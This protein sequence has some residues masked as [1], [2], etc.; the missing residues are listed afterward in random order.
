[1]IYSNNDYIKG[2]VYVTKNAIQID[3][4]N[5]DAYKNIFPLSQYYDYF[6]NEMYEVIG[7]ECTKY[8]YDLPYS[9]FSIPKNLHDEDGI[10]ETTIIENNI[11]KRI[12]WYINENGFITTIVKS[13][14]RY[15]EV[16][17]ELKNFEIL[18]LPLSPP[19][20]YFQD[21][22]SI[23]YY[24][25]EM[26][27]FHSS[28]NNN[29]PNG[30][31]NSGLCILS[32]CYCYNG[33]EGKDCNIIGKDMYGGICGNGIVEKGEE[34]DDGNYNNHDCCDNDC[35]VTNIGLTC[36][37]TEQCK[38][39]FGIC[40][41]EGTCE[42]ENDNEASCSDGDYCTDD[43]CINGKCVSTYNA[44]ACPVNFHSKRTIDFEC[45][46]PCTPDLNGLCDYKNSSCKHLN[47][48]CIKYTCQSGRCRPYILHKVECDDKN[49]CTYDDKCIRGECV[50][51]R[52]D[53][54][55]LDDEC[56]K[57]VCNRYTGNCEEKILN[58]TICRHYGICLNGTCEI[59]YG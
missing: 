21:T 38:N 23:Q 1:M 26:R 55:S 2:T 42:A 50:G 44:L 11:K 33:F 31:S 28:P 39:L 48:E 37:S 4:D 52:Y 57:G 29:C 16:K 6:R 18:R 15:I 24:C 41:T 13:N 25:S 14:D 35:K 54:S 30:C 45:Y 56:I 49:E 27:E 19:T 32:N 43:V 36:I 7:S 34:C 9:M 47:T 10:I 51:K 58:G 40:S 22:S 8:H 53:C 59:I 5:M 46:D 3:Y 17:I 12:R 20:I